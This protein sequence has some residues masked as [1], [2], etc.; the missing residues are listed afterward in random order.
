MVDQVIR[1]IQPRRGL[2]EKGPLL[3][4]WVQRGLRGQGRRACPRYKCCRKVTWM[5][6]EKETRFTG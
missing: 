5:G 4:G 1:W 6:T 2:Y 3:E